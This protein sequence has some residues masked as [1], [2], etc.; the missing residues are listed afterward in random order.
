MPHHL[1]LLLRLRVHGGRLAEP[2]KHVRRLSVSTAPRYRHRLTLQILI[3]A[4]RLA[5]FALLHT[6]LLARWRQPHTVHAF[7]GLQRLRLTP[8]VT[9]LLFAARRQ[10][11]W[12]AAKQELKEVLTT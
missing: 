9:S 6:L 2:V 1:R 10:L 11:T 12:R 4:L 7:R 5:L 8:W 3:V